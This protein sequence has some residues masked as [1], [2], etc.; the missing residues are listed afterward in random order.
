MEFAECF[1]PGVLDGERKI[2]FFHSSI[3]VEMESSICKI[4]YI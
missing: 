2:I 1:H 3:D 4:V